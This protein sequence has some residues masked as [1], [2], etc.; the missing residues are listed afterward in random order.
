[1]SAPANTP[2]SPPSVIVI[3]GGSG[4]GKTAIAGLL[5]GMPGWELADGDEFHPQA[6]VDKMKSG[7]PLT[8]E[9]RAPWLRAHLPVA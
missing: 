6:N 7:I 8:D 9:D 4:S 3:M 5:A 1:M 2:S